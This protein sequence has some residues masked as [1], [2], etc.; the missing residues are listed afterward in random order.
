MPVRNFYAAVSA[1]GRQAEKQRRGFVMLLVFA[2]GVLLGLVS[3]YLIDPTF[4]QR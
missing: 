1:N 3:W 4:F 2:V